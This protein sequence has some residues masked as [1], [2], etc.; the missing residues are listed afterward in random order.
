MYK[1]S[2]INLLVSLTVGLSIVFSSVVWAK[3]PNMAVSK[4]DSNGDGKVS[5]DEWEKPEFVFNKIDFNGDGFLTAEEF[6]KKWGISMPGASSNSA[7]V[8]SLD[9]S[10]IIIA[11]VHMHPMDQSPIEQL[12]WM[13]RNGVKWAGLG[14]MSEFSR[15]N[16][17]KVMKKR[18]IPFGGQGDMHRIYIQ[19]GLADIE[20][21]NN[22]IFQSMMRELEQQFENGEI[23]GVGEIFANNRTTNPK[24][25]MRRKTRI[26]APT[27]RA[28]LDLVEKY[29]GAMSM[30]VQWDSDSIE[31]LGILADHNPNGNII[32]AHCGND[33]T[34]YEVRKVL[35]KHIN[36]YCDLS[37]R[38]R[39][40][41]SDWVVNKRPQAEIFTSYNLNS[42]WKDLIEEMPDR[43]M[44][45]T[46]TK[47]GSKYDKGISNIRSGLLANLSQATA[48]KVAYKNAQRL[49]DLH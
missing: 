34:A 46:D 35:K 44:V 6:A 9:E 7:D 4:R 17:S 8:G 22:E 15:E 2:M 1:K 49:L 37:A 14:S 26:D 20:D 25:N 43:F 30:H 41:L 10:D 11:D 36:I 21:E 42:G 24:P 12:T 19:Y 40:K 16:F 48:E 27:Y 18:Y 3:N 31:Q 38:S 23:K 33:G 39:P 45:G 29:G 32:W 13:N 5:F 28:I 47:G